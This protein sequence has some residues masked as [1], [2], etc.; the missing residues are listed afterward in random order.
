VFALVIRFSA[1]K[2][3]HAPSQRARR[4]NADHGGSDAPGYFPSHELGLPAAVH[5]INIRLGRRR[6]TE[7][8]L[9]NFD[10]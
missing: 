9:H 8:L 7:N 4:N 3:L 2:R 6:S 1:S 5:T 10:I